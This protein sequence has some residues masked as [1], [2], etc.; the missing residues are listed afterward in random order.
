MVDDSISDPSK[1]GIDLILTKAFLLTLSG[2]G[3]ILTG[4]RQ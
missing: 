1:F 3:L 4:S 2:K